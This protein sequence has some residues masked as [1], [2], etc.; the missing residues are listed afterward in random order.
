MS[1]AAWK[2]WD[3]T[4]TSFQALVGQEV[5]SMNA[6]PMVSSKNTNWGLEWKVDE[7]LALYAY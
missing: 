6:S 7:Y 3:A 5:I 4:L 1:K 2:T